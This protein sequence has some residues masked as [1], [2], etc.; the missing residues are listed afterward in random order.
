[1]F[2]VYNP[3]FVRIGAGSFVAEYSIQSIKCL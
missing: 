1:M 2:C 3:F